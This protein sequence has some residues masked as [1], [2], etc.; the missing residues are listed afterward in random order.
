MVVLESSITCGIELTMLDF[1]T[2]HVYIDTNAISER[3]LFIAVL[4]IPNTCTVHGHEL[5]RLEIK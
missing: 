1:Q 3:Q 5:S 4:L 2:P